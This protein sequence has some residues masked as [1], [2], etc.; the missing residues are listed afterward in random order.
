VA[1]HLQKPHGPIFWAVARVARR[2]VPVHMFLKAS[3]PA[4]FQNPGVLAPEGLAAQDGTIVR[5][6]DEHGVTSTDLGCDMRC[7]KSVLHHCNI[8]QVAKGPEPLPNK[9]VPR[10]KIPVKKPNSSP[11]KLGTRCTLRP[12]HGHFL[13]REFC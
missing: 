4:N 7:S 10:A 12:L 6:T 9:V 2:I 8:E 13:T 3:E 5:S 11:E 1:P